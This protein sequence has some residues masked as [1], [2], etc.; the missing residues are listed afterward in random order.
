MNV[1]P[2]LKKLGID[3]SMSVHRAIHEVGIIVNDAPNRLQEANKIIQSLGAPR[4]LREERIAEIVAKGLVEQ[5]VIDPMNFDPEKAMA[6]A[7]QKYEKILSLYPYVLKHDVKVPSP[8]K[9]GKRASRKNNDKKA[10]AEELFNANKEK[11]NGDIAK[12]IST[13]LEITYAN[14]YYYVSRVFK[15]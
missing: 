15:R 10:R 12:L 8:S 3:P 1:T 2:V 7:N 13:E 5:A 6:I 9:P 11:S 4:V 14:A